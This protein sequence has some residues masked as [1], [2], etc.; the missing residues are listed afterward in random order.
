MQTWLQSNLLPVV[1][2]RL[3][4][5]RDIV[6]AE[7]LSDL[8][9]LQPSMK[10][11]DSLLCGHP[12]LLEYWLKA[13]VQ[14]AASQLFIWATILVMEY[15]IVHNKGL[16]INIFEIFLIKGA[17]YVATRSQ[18]AG[19]QTATERSPCASQRHH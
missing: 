11:L 4:K 13:L 9:M 17:V 15:K 5:I 14:T 16:S 3:L 6:I 19:L 18:G 7:K 12:P 2:E 10:S 1:V 8:A